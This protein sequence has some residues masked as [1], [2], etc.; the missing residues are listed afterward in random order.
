MQPT[1]HNLLVINIYLLYDYQ[2]S[3]ELNTYCKFYNGS[4]SLVPQ[5]DKSHNYYNETVL[6]LHYQT[7]DTSGK[8]TKSK[9]E[10]TCFA[11]LF[12]YK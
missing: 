1:V 8:C 11:Y 12:F 2:T 4:N 7:A 5:L 10:K 6:Y 9:R 3:E